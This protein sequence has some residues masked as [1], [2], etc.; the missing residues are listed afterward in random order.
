MHELPIKTGPSS[1]PPDMSAAKRAL[2]EKYL[3]GSLAPSTDPWTVPRRPLDQP[4]LASLGQEQ[5]W[6]HAQL[7]DDQL[8]YNEPVTVRRTGPLDLSALKQSLREIIRRHEAWRT[9]FAIADGQLLQVINPEFDL[10]LPLV[11][12]RALPEAEREAEALRLATIDARKPFNLEAGPLLRGMLA[13]LGDEEHRLYLTLHQIIFDGVSLYSVFLPE[14]TALYEAYA[15]GRPSP[16]TD[17]PVQYADFA[18]WQRQPDRN[19]ELS[20]QIAYWKKQLADPPAGLDL[21]T[22]RPRPAIQT[23]NGEQLSFTFP[24]SLSDS[25]KALSRREGTTLFMTLLTAFQTVLHRHTDQDD[26]LVGTVTT[27]RKRSEFDQML[28]FFLNTLVLRTDLSNDPTFLELLARTRKVTVEAL[29]HSDLPIHRLVKELDRER[30][31]AR[32]PLF[33]V[34]FVL[35][36]P[37]PEPG[38]GW[39]LSQVDVD[40]GIARVDLYLELDDRPQGLFGRIRYNRDLFAASSIERMLDHLTTLLEGIT[41]DP[42]RAISDYPLGI[43]RDQMSDTGVPPVNYSPHPLATNKRTNQIRPANTFIE[44]TKAEIEQ[45]IGSRFESIVKKY[46]NRIAIKTRRHEWTYVE[47]NRRADQIAGTILDLLGEGEDHVA[48]LFEHDAP[49]IA[50]MLGALKAGKTYV[51]LDPGHPHERLVH[52]IK[53]SQATVVLT[54]CRNLAQAQEVWSAVAERSDDTALDNVENL[55]G[56]APSQLRPAGALDNYLINIDDEIAFAARLN[57]KDVR[58]DNVAYILYTS[59]ST[60]QPKGVMQ[61]HRNVLHH[62]RAYTNNLHLNCDDRL[63]LFSSYCFD[64]SVMDIYGALLNGATL[65]PI[66]I[67]ED[68]LEDLSRYLADQRITVYHSTPTVYRYFINTVTQTSN[69]GDQVSTVSGP[70]SRRG[71]PARRGAG[72]RV[73]LPDLR[74]VVLGGE[75]VVRTDVESYQRHFSDNCLFVNGLGPTEATVVLQNFIDKQTEF[76]GASIPVGFPVAG[77]EVLL[78]NKHGKP[79]EIAGEIAIKSEHVAL[80][81]WRN[82]E[83]TAN[84]FVVHA[85]SMHADAS[86]GNQRIYRTGDLGR[87]LPDGSIQFEGRKDFQVKIRGFRI[88]LGEIEAALAQHPSVREGV[89]VANETGNG[90]QRLVAYV[91]SHVG[92]NGSWSSDAA[93]ALSPNSSPSGKGEG[94]SDL[95]EFLRRKLP[96]YMVPSSVVILDSL[97]LTASGKLNR[98]ALPAPAGH[99]ERAKVAPQTRLEKSLAAIW[100]DVLQVEAIGANDNFFELGGHSLLAVRLFAQIEK[101]LGRHMP[102]STLFQAPTVAQLATVIQKDSTPEFSSLVAIQPSGAKTPF[103]CVHALGGNVLEY[104]E[105][106][107]HLGTDQPFYGFQSAGLNG[108]DAAHTRV[109]EMAAHYIK[110]MRELQPTGPYFIGGRSL[111]GMVAFEMAQQLRSMKEE[112]GILALLDTYPSGYARLL[113]EQMT[114]RGRLRLAVRRTR[115]H[116]GNIR[117]LSLSEKASYVVAKSKFAPRKLKSRLWRRL[118]RSFQNLGRELPR[119]L[120]DIQELNSLAVRRYVPTVYEGY[121]TLF[122]ASQDLRASV[123]FV[124]G[125]RELAA[126]GLEV[127]EIPGTH[128]DLVKEPHV[129]ELASKLQSCLDSSQAKAPISAS[130]SQE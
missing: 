62:I 65:Y 64:A 90:D 115:S 105:L 91:V 67:K 123:D 50:A 104:R 33:Q 98:L 96:E 59:G 73:T 49:M 70:G 47:L 42:S 35:E 126:G 101:K 121:V 109:E 124:E 36:P 45:S 125:W 80:G 89:V 56:K 57:L 117:G 92:H 6:I 106:A 3:R 99:F 71:L 21:P 22:D 25:L 41:A 128:L 34:M 87:R 78:L 54:N 44:F 83:A 23:F 95:R 129:S 127:H 13:R 12:L 31:A 116:L 17:I 111:G 28:G 84:A 26:L 10:E 1:N 4:A 93:Q 51:P 69:N 108:K 114:L 82:D 75:K 119:A 58:P 77:T 39:H 66:D 32:N 103:F 120:Q 88:E 74:L 16:L 24:Q 7:V 11:D 81:Y 9:N 19:E 102:L 100:A 30:D 61:N 46:P 94:V 37:L 48:L 86:S 20:E 118:H 60:G 2:L 63:T 53:H 5:L 97:P 38:P 40:A 18:Y 107:K 112:I 8:I 29:A 43:D 110:E 130:T 27:S 15:G 85:A 55:E 68:G 52:L 79:T 122:W 72:D 113:R 76:S 14:L